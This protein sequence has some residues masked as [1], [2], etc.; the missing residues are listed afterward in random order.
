MRQPMSLAQNQTGALWAR[1][2][3]RRHEIA[4]RVSADLISMQVYAPDYFAAFSPEK[5]FEKWAAAEVSAI[6]A[7][8]EGMEAYTLSGGLYAVF[9]YKGSSADTRI[10]QYI[11]GEWLPASG[12]ALDTRPHFEVLGERYKNND[13]DSEEEIWVPIRG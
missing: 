10:S 12:Y 1:F 11:F 2:M 13:P 9:S 5:S 3:P 6:E 8:P 4:H 7:I